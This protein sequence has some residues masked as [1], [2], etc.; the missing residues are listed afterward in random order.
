MAYYGGDPL[1]INWFP[2][3]ALYSS[4]G[5]SSNSYEEKC[6][7][8]TQLQ[9]LDGKD[10]LVIEGISNKIDQLISRNNVALSSKDM[11]SLKSSIVSEIG[12][13]TSKIPNQSSGPVM[14]TVDSVVFNDDVKKILSDLVNEKAESFAKSYNDIGRTG[15]ESHP[16]LG[17]TRIRYFNKQLYSKQEDELMFMFRNSS[18]EL[19]IPSV[20]YEVEGEYN[21]SFALTIM[22]IESSRRY[23]DRSQIESWVRARS[24]KDNKL[25][26]RETMKDIKGHVTRKQ[27]GQL[28]LNDIELLRVIHTELI[29][30]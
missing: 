9:K 12:N 14:C 3:L 23:I 20:D 25:I 13:I 18:T 29:D 24:K 11:A 7:I 6:K 10:R 26:S 27:G 28:V 19:T 8:G 17:E 4:L 1:G 21:T 15:D 2:M 16:M 5:K 22:D 30:V